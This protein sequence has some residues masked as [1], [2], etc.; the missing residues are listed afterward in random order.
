[1]IADEIDSMLCARGEEEN[2]ASRRVKT[3][4]LLQF[5]GVTT[6]LT[7]RVL[8]LGATNR[9]F[10]LDDGVLRRFPRRIF[11]DLPSMEA[12]ANL[13]LNNFK[14]TK[15]SSRLSSSELRQ[16]AER[17][18][19]YSFSDLTALCRE[20]SM[21][22][23]RGLSR[24]QLQRVSANQIR[25]VQ[26]QDLEKALIVIRPSTSAANQQKLHDFARDYAQI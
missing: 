22:P 7:D 25:P 18:S 9:P 26:Y 8:V 23:I 21:G 14:L 11:I 16:I 12:R 6:D 24:S 20:A 1:M 10:D 15:T 4:F 17:T 13:I 5:D 19:G 2:G 3:A